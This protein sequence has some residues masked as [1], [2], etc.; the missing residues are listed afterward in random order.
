LGFQVKRLQVG[1][2]RRLSSTTRESLVTD[3]STILAPH[4]LTRAREIAT[5]M[6]KPAD[7]VATTA[8]LLE[9][10]RPLAAGWLID[11]TTQVKC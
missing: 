7:S 8:D 10:S 1:T 2:A 4:Y 3:L 9:K 5:R 11:A 6:T